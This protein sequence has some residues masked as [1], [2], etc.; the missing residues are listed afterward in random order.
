VTFTLPELTQ[1]I[2]ET[3]RDELLEVDASFGADTDLIGAGLDSL[4]L[5]QLLLTVEERTGL[6]FDESELTPENLTSCASLARCIH[7]QLAAA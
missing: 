3:L 7:D 6:W 4:A 2:L 1:L 5:T